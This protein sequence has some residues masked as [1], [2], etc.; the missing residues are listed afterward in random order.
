MYASG[1]IVTISAGHS[2]LCSVDHSEQSNDH[3]SDQSVVQAQEQGGHEGGEPDGLKESQKASKGR[4]NNSIRKTCTCTYTRTHAHAHTQAHKCTYTLCLS[5]TADRIN[6]FP[7]IFIPTTGSC[8]RTL[9]PQ[10]PRL[11]SSILLVLQKKGRSENCMNIPFRL[12]ITMAERTACNTVR[13]PVPL[14]HIHR[15]NFLLASHH[16]PP[17]FPT[18]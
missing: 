6:N 9:Y 16:L 4:V 7:A 14:R 10:P 11:T 17:A 13:P 12:T 3:S 1:H 18:L 5:N 2:P 15:A 8:R